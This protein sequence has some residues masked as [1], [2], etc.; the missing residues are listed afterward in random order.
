M[1]CQVRNNILQYFTLAPFAYWSIRSI[2]SD[3]LGEMIEVLS[4]N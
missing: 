4:A 2:V 3:D 1:I